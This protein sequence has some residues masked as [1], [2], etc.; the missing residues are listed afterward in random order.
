MAQWLKTLA[1]SLEIPGSFPSIHIIAHNHHYLKFQLTIWFLWVSG[2]HE[3]KIP[4][5]IE[6]FI[7]IWLVKTDIAFIVHV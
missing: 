2:T 3:G 4:T 7:H 6:L 1:T 5:H